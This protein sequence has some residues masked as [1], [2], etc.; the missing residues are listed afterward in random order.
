MFLTH[1]TRILFLFVDHC[2]C[3]DLGLS[4]FSVTAGA[5]G[6]VMNKRPKSWFTDTEFRRWS[7]RKHNNDRHYYRTRVLDN[8]HSKLRTL[9]SR[10]RRC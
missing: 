9:K 10:T 8:S 2:T 7:G 5:A 3:F 6:R 4:E 1:P